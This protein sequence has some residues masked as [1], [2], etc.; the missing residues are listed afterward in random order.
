MYIYIYIY[1]HIR[2]LSAAAEDNGQA[3]QGET[4]FHACPGSPDRTW[5]CSYLTRCC[6]MKVVSLGRGGRRRFLDLVFFFSTQITKTNSPPP[7]VRVK[8]APP[9]KGSAKR[10]GSHETAAAASRQTLPLLFKCIL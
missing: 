7:Q 1:T 4:Y 8:A 5:I 3:S 6:F 2:I 9:R 10:G